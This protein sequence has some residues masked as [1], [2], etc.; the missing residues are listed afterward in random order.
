M[1]A[2]IEAN[3]S[4]WALRR[5]EA[6]E[7]VKREEIELSR[8]TP[9]RGLLP[10]PTSALPAALAAAGSITLTNTFLGPQYLAL[11]DMLGGTSKVLNIFSPLAVATLALAVR[12]SGRSNNQKDSGLGIAGEDDLL[13]QGPHRVTFAPILAG[14]AASVASF[15]VRAAVEGASLV[16]LATDLPIALALG[17]LAAAP[18]GR[19]AAGALAG[20][21]LGDAIGAYLISAFLAVGYQAVLPALAALN[22]AGFALHRLLKNADSAQEKSLADT[23]G[24]RT[25]LL[26][27]RRGSI[28]LFAASLALMAGVMQMAGLPV[29]LAGLI[30]LA[31]P[32][33]SITTPEG[34][35]KVAYASEAVTAKIRRWLTL[36]LPFM[37]AAS[38]AVMILGDAGLAGALGLANTIVEEAP[39]VVSHSL[40]IWHP[41]ALGLVGGLVASASVVMPLAAGWFTLSGLSRFVKVPVVEDIP[42]TITERC[43]RVAKFLATSPVAL[44]AAAALAIKPL[45]AAALLRI[46]LFSN[47][48]SKGRSS[49]IEASSA[50]S[51]TQ[52]I[53]DG[54]QFIISSLP[55]IALGFGTAMRAVEPGTA[56]LAVT[57]LSI[58]WTIA[59]IVSSP[60]APSKSGGNSLFGGNK[61]SPANGPS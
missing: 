32:I 39:G 29:A 60:K 54:R 55:L 34:S 19:A 23:G 24:Q 22:V 3:I 7:T 9:S 4:G 12:R 33:P 35:A 2:M 41:M 53:S 5:E 58:L 31:V 47:P 51:A 38:G 49:E 30:A 36:I 46:M 6:E 14:L 20:L 18:R 11:W 28:I 57:V 26:R 25:G 42:E 45:V 15:G 21:L 37:A 13:R 56:R 40:R 17:G 27:I 44:G 10:P 16:P 1:R 50:T 48:F 61:M 8:R 59:F 52:Q 43:V